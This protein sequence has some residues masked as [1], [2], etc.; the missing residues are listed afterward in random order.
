MSDN[1]TAGDRGRRYYAS[2]AAERERTRER[3]LGEMLQI[4]CGSLRIEVYPSGVV[5]SDGE[6]LWTASAGALLRGA[7]AVR[8]KLASIRRGTARDPRV[9]PSLRSRA[10]ALT[11]GRA[12][13]PADRQGVATGA[14]DARQLVLKIDIARARSG[15][16]RRL[17]R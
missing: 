2:R 3:I 17:D 10:G 16:E 9:R 7:Q 1:A 14:R 4:D 6:A 15:A 12:A 11:R 8:A 13:A 5:V